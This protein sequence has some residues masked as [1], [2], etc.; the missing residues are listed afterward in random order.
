MYGRPYGKITQLH[1]LLGPDSLANPNPSAYQ[2]GFCERNN[3]EPHS[4]HVTP[5]PNIV[6]QDYWEKVGRYI[7]SLSRTIFN[8]NIL[9]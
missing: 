1:G 9:K 8:I 6:N 7:K 2:Y 4:I 3:L 5:N